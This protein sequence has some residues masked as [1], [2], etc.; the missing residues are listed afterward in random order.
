MI[1][2][3]RNNEEIRKTMKERQYLIPTRY[4]LDMQKYPHVP[5]VVATELYQLCVRQEMT[6][7]GYRTMN[8]VWEKICSIDPEWDG[9]ILPLKDVY[10]E[11]MDNVKQNLLIYD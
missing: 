2:N 3:I 8:N 7:R 10:K 9:E 1:D 6:K 11:K 4:Y 5:W